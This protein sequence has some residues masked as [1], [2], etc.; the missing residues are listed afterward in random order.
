[1]I[2]S[3]IVEDAPIVRKGIRLLLK[4][5]RDIEIVGEAGDG[6]EAVSQITA[7]R[8]DLLFLDIQ[9]PGFDGFEVLERTSCTHL[10]PVIFITAHADHALRA[11]DANALSYLLKPIDPARF[12]EVLQ[13]AR[14]LR[15]DER[16]LEANHTSVG[17]LLPPPDPADARSSVGL[18]GSET[19]VS[20]LVVKDGD[21]FLLVKAEEIDWVASTGEYASLR[22]GKKSFLIRMALSELERKLDPRHFARIH[23]STI[24]NL[25]R[26]HEIRSRSHG[27]CDVLL[28]DG[29]VLRL[30][31]S[32]RDNLLA[33]HT[34][35]VR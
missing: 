12:R 22:T 28:H 14:L 27:D 11:F 5:E 4:E 7:L 34:T 26:V 17:R 35:S 33:H 3:L 9:M 25:D 13:R 23:R 2:R 29:T 8:P 24:V 15:G 1:M 31:R 19:S 20:R 16:R 32:Y 6:P 21:R 18:A 30:S 10:C